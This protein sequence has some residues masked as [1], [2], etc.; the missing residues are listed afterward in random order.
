M[1]GSECASMYQVHIE[2]LLQSNPSILKVNT[3]ICRLCRTRIV[4]VYQRCGGSGHQ[5]LSSQTTCLE[6]IITKFNKLSHQVLPRS[7]DGNAKA[8]E[9]P[10]EDKM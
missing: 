7:V 10:N 6:S 1:A 2:F 9:I 4:A 3:V 5:A 8:E